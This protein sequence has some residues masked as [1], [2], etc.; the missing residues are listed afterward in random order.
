[1]RSRKIFLLLIILLLMTI[2]FIGCKVEV[3]ESINTDTL[4]EFTL[5]ELSK[6]NGKDGNSAYVA[7]DGIVYDVT[8]LSRWKNGDHNG[9]EAGND[10]TEPIKTKSP[11]GVSMLKRAKI[12]GKLVN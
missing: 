9:Y 5:E 7:V 6:F 1:M 10:L 2:V 11:H 4:P 3:E 8:E 12:V